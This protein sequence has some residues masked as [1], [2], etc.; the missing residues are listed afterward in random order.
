VTEPGFARLH[1]WID[2][3][4]QGVGFRAFVYE[5]ALSQDL[6]G[7]VRNTHDGLVEALG[8]GP[9]ENLDILL[10]YIRRG[11]RG[12][13]VTEVREEWSRATG[14]YADFRVTRTI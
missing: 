10:A 12:A 14:E 9:R 8:E 3:H 2:G 1:A 5:I 13:F 4:V 11:P 7:W 6:T